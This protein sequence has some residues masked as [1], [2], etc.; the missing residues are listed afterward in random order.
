M[1]YI[2]LIYDIIGKIMIEIYAEVSLLT[3]DLFPLMV[4]KEN[5]FFYHTK[6]IWGWLCEPHEKKNAHTQNAPKVLLP[7]GT[8]QKMKK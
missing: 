2:L 5:I 4:Q 8:Q 7:D 6:E 1:K 3:E